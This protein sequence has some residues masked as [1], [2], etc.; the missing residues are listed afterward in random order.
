MKT[1]DLCEQLKRTDREIETCR[2]NCDGLPESEKW[3]ALLGEVDWLVNRQ[4]ILEE[5]A[6][7]AKEGG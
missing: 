1:L 2:R 7:L 4:M 5:I 6:L 3:M